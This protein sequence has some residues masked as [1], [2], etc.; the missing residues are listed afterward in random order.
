[1]FG[2]WML[3][4]WL[5]DVV[6]Y[7]VFPCACNT[8]QHDHQPTHPRVVRYYT[9]S[10]VTTEQQR[11][12]FHTALDAA[13]EWLYG[14]GDGEGAPA[15]KKKLKEL[16]AL[17]EPIDLRV[18]EAMQR[19]QVVEEATKW[20]EITKLVCNGVDDV[21]RLMCWWWLCAGVHWVH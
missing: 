6:F 13:E 2:L 21:T 7:K 15:F 11:S 19:P 9:M 8:T 1:M 16:T 3:F 12:H 17:G 5:C 4:L 18:R 14:D 10:Q 20:V